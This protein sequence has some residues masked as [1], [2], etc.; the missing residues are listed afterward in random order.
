ME[1]ILVKW[2]GSL[3]TDKRRPGHARQSVIDRLS[4][5]LKEG[6]RGV[7]KGDPGGKSARIVLGHGSGSFGHAAAHR[8]GLTGQPDLRA[9]PAGL[10]S[11]MEVRFEAT[12]LH[13][14][15]TQSLIRA[16]NPAWTL[17]PSAA[18]MAKAGRPSRGDLTPFFA[19]LGQGLLPV[20][21][22]D[23][24][25]DSELGVSIASTEA[26][27]RFLVGRLARRG[28]VVR[29]LL[30]MG[31]TAGIY[32]RDGKTIPRVD[33]ENLPRVKK[34]IE[35]P[36]GIDVTGG[37]LLRLRTAWELAR[38]GIDSWILDG[39]APGL[40]AAALRGDLATGQFVGGAIPGT[41]VAAHRRA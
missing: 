37:M 16:G 31:E 38:L 40:F 29:R 17:C 28:L 23:V 41:H 10:L 27:M 35:A 6:R 5:E 13:A 21:Y 30:W 33:G 12:R 8:L 3:I 2:G 34:M 11:A 15:V 9:D 25:V 7:E 4:D 39:T 19:A 18:L 24:L 14:L 20:T 26:L 1:L 36:A 22:G 32:D